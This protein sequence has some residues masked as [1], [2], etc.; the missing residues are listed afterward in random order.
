MV[1]ELGGERLVRPI[2]LGHHHQARRV[3]VEPVHDAGPLDA[4]DAGERTLAMVQERVDERAGI[5]AGARVDDEARGLVDH[6]QLGVLMHDGERNVLRLR[7]GGDG[8]RHLDHD[9]LAGLHLL[10]GARHHLAVDADLP[11]INERFQTA[12]RQ[13]RRFAGLD[14][15]ETTRQIGVDA[16]GLGQIIRAHRHR[17]G[18]AAHVF[19][20]ELRW[21]PAHE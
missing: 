17:G 14:F 13:I 16:L 18:T 20:V 11:G 9:R 4:A 15:R 21:M 5:V 1:G 12:A 8:G 10:R 19:V 3:L 2:G 6:D 7:A